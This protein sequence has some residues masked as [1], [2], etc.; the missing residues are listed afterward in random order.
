MIANL[1]PVSLQ[2]FTFCI[3][4]LCLS[5]IY[6][7]CFLCNKVQ[8]SFVPFPWQLDSTWSHIFPNVVKKC[9]NLYRIDR[10]VC[11]E[12]SQVNSHKYCFPVKQILWISKKSPIL[13]PLKR[14]ILLIILMSSRFFLSGIYQKL[15]RQYIEIEVFVAQ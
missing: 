15:S 7:C 9:L 10:I 14:N 2:V 8:W 13:W 12:S 5:G 1:W 4:F 6:S 11:Q 3:I